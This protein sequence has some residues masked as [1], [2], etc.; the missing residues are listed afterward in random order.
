MSNWFKDRRQEFIAATL[1][2]FGQIRRAEIMREFDIT[3]AIA[4][5][6]I[7]IFLAADPPHVRYDVSA[8][9]YILEE[10]APTPDQ[11]AEN[12]KC[13]GMEERARERFQLWFFR[14]L[15]NGERFK[16][17]SLFGLP[18]EEIGQTEGWQRH[19]LRAILAALSAQSGGGR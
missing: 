9:A 10:Q 13:S 8:K 5:S 16:L 3:A 12:A 6:D 18:V 4:S 2:Q 15:L 19:A 14:D 1:R 7:S 17:F 11:P